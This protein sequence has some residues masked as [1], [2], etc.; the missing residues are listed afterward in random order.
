[1]E[2][3]SQLLLDDRQLAKL[4]FKGGDLSSILIFRHN[5]DYLP[6]SQS[7]SFEVAS[8]DRMSMYKIFLSIT[9]CSTAEEACLLFVCTGEGMSFSFQS[10]IIIPSSKPTFV[11][12]QPTF[13][14]CG[15]PLLSSS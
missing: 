7:M 4:V 12:S 2:G 9:A 15:A 1:M 14:G 5:L 11:S 10:P 3:S 13:V 8:S 6:V